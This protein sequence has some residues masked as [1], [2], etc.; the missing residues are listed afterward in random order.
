MYPAKS[1]L[2]D[3]GEMFVLPVE[4]L[5]IYH[6]CTQKC[7]PIMNGSPWKGG[8]MFRW[9]VIIL[10]RGCH[11]DSVWNLFEECMQKEAL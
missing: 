9:V 6:V 3:D 2:Q 8:A 4:W 10:V 7:V 11:N 1:S 5:F